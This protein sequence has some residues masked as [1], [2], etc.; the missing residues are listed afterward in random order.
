MSKRWGIFTFLLGLVGTILA[1]AAVISVNNAHSRVTDVREELLTAIQG[2]RMND[3][4]TL[5]NRIEAVRTD[6]GN[7]QT[8]LK[9]VSSGLQA[10]QTKIGQLE[11]SFSGL[12]RRVDGAEG[13]LKALGQTVSDLQRATE[14][15]RESLA[16][17]NPTDIEARLQRIERALEELQKSIA[18][19]EASQVR[20]AVVDAE[21]LFVRVFLPQVEPE[22]RALLTKAQAIQELQAKYAQG[23]I[24]AGAYP[25]EYAKLAAE[26]LEAQ[27][28]VNMSM[29]EKML[30]S[31]GFANLRVDL[32]N[33]KDRAKPL[34]D[35]VQSLVKQ[36][37]VAVLDYN[38]F[39]AELQELQ[40]AFQQVDQLLTQVAAVKILEVS[41]KLAQEKGFDIVLRTKDVVMYLRSPAISDLTADVEQ[42]LWGLFAQL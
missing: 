40:T 16:V 14:E 11:Q 34:A 28:Q 39:S 29:L 38:A 12:A 32:Q 9:G 19:L 23:R 36:A 18:A 6:L 27:V 42:A 21:G 24:P 41:Q 20:I 3:L 25:Q 13:E 35:R 37:Q 5:S 22:R 4:R 7:M 30:A 8:D 2:L 33:L 10:V 1:L 15:V 31:P 17:H 26:Y